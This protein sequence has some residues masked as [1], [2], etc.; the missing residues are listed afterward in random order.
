MMW[1]PC[2]RAAL[3]VSGIIAAAPALAITVGT[4]NA[5]APG[6]P[7]ATLGWVSGAANPQPAVVNAGG[8]AGAGDAYLKLVPGGGA[9][10]LVLISRA[11][12]WTGDYTAAGVTGIAMDLN[13]LGSAD[14]SL[15]LFL[16]DPNL[17]GSFSASAVLLPAGS[18]W[19]HAFFPTSPAALRDAAAPLLAPSAPLLV[20]ELRLYHATGAVGVRSADAVATTLGVDNITA[21]PEPAAVWLMLCGLVAGALRRRGH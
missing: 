14:L 11:P 8:P 1:G 10:R 2:L 3:A 17:A 7:G 12:D 21:V 4:V 6:S 16:G 9:G 20:P 15:R 18:G 13:N 19:R 5:F